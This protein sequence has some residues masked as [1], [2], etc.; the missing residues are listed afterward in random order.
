MLVPAT[1]RDTGYGALFEK[2]GIIVGTR[3]DGGTDLPRDALLTYD[4]E[5]GHQGH[6]VGWWHIRRGT[7]YLVNQNC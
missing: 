4:A 5:L 3:K 7:G 2:V 6:G 1:T